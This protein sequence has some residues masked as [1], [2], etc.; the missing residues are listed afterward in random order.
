MGIEE[1]DKSALS[2][3][4]LFTLDQF[5]TG[6]LCIFNAA[7]GSLNHNN[8]KIAVG[9]RMI[10]HQVR[11]VVLSA[12]VAAGTLSMGSVAMG[13][14]TLN[15]ILDEGASANVIAQES[16]ARINDIVDDTD[17]VITQYKNVLKTV[18]GLKVYNAQMERS[19]ERQMQSMEELTV[20]IKNVTNIKRQV[21]PLL[22][23]MIDGL[24]L[25][26]NSDIPFHLEERL[27]GLDRVKDLMT[28]PDIDAS[29]RFRS[30]FE[31][32]QIESDYGGVFQSYQETRM[33]D[34]VERFVDMLMV[35]RVAL[36]YQTTDGEVSGA[37][38]KDTKEFEV[39]DQATFQKSINTAIRM[40]NAKAPQNTLLL[41]PIS[42]PENAQ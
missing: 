11:T 33:I 7:V 41:L 26:I 2:T 38:N 40:A 1:N 30:V 4:T 22:V 20:N 8:S 10:K 16:Q 13:Q 27:A 9:R 35:G 15:E 17:K 37:Y 39:V 6:S 29:E 5:F 31:L 34:G 12:F 18:D 32:Y 14:T 19:I 21:E 24:E 36:L 25:F 23:R 28:N 3:H 42:A